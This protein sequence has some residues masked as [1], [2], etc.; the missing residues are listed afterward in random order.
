MASAWS[1]RFADRS[2]IL[3]SKAPASERLEAL[4]FVV[5]LVADV[6]QP[7]HAGY[8]DDKGGNL[9]QVQAF[10]HGS[11]LHAAWDSGLIEAWPGGAGALRSSA[12]KA[13]T[14]LSMATEPERWAEESCRLVAEE[15]FHPSARKID[16]VYTARAW[17]VV[18]DRLVGAGWRLAALLNH[19]LR[20][21]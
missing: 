21:P 14:T 10:G 16:A 20:A 17:P 6:H 15:G 5:H 3:A 18:Q 11:N 12:L 8:A 1:G 13:S 9:Y 19:A 4:K 2:A 7:L